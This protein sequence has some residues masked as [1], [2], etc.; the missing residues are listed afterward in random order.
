[1]VR[2]S[3]DPR[4]LWPNATRISAH[5]A[6]VVR[7]SC[8]P[9]DDPRRYRCVR[10]AFASVVRGSCDPRDQLRRIARN[11]KELLQWF[12]DRVIPATRFHAGLASKLTESF[13]GSGIV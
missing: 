3:C 1:M 9:R 10:G 7:G 12:G 6:S 4:D 5:H 8:D 13:S 11:Q 2:G